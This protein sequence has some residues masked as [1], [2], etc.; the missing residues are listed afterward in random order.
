MTVATYTKQMCGL[1]SLFVHTAFRVRKTNK[2]FLY[3]MC[4]NYRFNLTHLVL[5]QF[6]KATTHL[7]GFQ[8]GPH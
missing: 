7:C 5:D 2:P 3:E 4:M 1:M 8:N 6:L